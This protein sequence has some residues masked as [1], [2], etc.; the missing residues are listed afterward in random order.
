MCIHIFSGYP[1]V[2]FHILLDD[3]E[4]ETFRRLAEREGKSLGEWMREAARVRARESESES[5]LDTVEALEAFFADSDRRQEGQGHEPD[6]EI[7]KRVIDESM[8]SGG[9]PS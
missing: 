7:H 1:M 3:D 8:R 6:W 9:D 4:K 2:R 5:R